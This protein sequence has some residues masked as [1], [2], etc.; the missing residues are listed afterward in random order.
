MQSVVCNDSASQFGTSVVNMLFLTC[1]S[2]VVS[3]GSIFDIV[4]YSCICQQQQHKDINFTDELAAIQLPEDYYC[5][6]G[7]TKLITNK[8]SSFLFE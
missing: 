5:I 6:A 7:Y 8:Y 3:H 1:S 4:S 2:W